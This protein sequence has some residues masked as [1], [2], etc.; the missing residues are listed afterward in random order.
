MTAPQQPLQ[1][2][3]GSLLQHEGAQ[4]RAVGDGPDHGVGEFAPLDVLSEGLQQLERVFAVVVAIHLYEAAQRCGAPRRRVARL[5]RVLERGAELRAVSCRS[6]GAL[7]D[8][9]LTR[10][11]ARAQLRLYIAPRAATP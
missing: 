7:R 5:Q 1:R 11:Q 2:G 3:A 10:R 8:T 9:P 4:V 6:H